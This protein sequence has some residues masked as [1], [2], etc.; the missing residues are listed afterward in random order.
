MRE[1]D[2]SLV[3][4][5]PLMNHHQVRLINPPMIHHQVRLLNPQ[6]L[7]LLVRPLPNCISTTS[8]NESAMGFQQSR[9]DI[10]YQFCDS[11]PRADE[12]NERISKLVKTKRSE[13]I[14]PTNDPSS[15]PTPK[16]TNDPSTD[17]TLQ[18]TNEPS[19][20]PTPQHRT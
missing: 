14:R 8:E 11:D 12:T 16:L 5:N 4:L 15:G 13:R 3:T 19:S 20:G 1:N 7:H 17:L 10:G 6:V 18:S 9:G 2:C